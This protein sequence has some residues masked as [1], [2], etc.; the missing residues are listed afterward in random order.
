ML[1]DDV[2]V[3][4]FVSWVP[5]YAQADEAYNIGPAASAQSYLRGEK[6]VDLAH[7]TGAEARLLNGF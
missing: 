7:K 1:E 2:V 3:L 5:T 6:L 4:V